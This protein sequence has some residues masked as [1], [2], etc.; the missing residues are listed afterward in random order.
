MFHT[1]IVHRHNDWMQWV[2]Q[3][4]I[5]NANLIRILVLDLA[6]GEFDPLLGRPGERSSE[7]ELSL[8][9]QLLDACGQVNHSAMT[10]NVWSQLQH[11]CG[12]LPFQSLYLI[13][14]GEFVGFHPRTICSIRK[15]S[16]TSPSQ[17]GD[18]RGPSWSTTSAPDR[19]RRK[20][21]EVDARPRWMVR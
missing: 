12:A 19:A 17:R 7:E 5:P 13:W 14:D 21:P 4:L 16:R 3:A 6:Q 9:R 2:K 20:T 1:A 10:W 18:L 15:S 11:E 8:L